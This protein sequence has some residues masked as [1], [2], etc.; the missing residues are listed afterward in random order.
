MMLSPLLP[1]SGATFCHSSSVMKGMIG[2]ARRSVVSST[3][4]RVRRV[5]RCWASLPLCDLHLG[6]FHI[7]VAVL[8]PDEFV[9]GARGQVEAVVGESLVP[10]R[11][12]RVAGG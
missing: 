6:Q 11:S 12:R 10:L 3:R 2:C 1:A 7:P 5:A 8:V 4:T 9:D